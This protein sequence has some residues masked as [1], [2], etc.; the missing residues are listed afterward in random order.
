MK[1]GNPAAL[2]N[3][4]FGK[5]LFLKLFYFSLGIPFDVA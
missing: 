2:E 1:Y 4:S 5:E 3:G